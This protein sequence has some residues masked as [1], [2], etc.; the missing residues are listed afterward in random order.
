MY[1][2]E[3]APKFLHRT[4]LAFP[5]LLY[6][7]V[8][9]TTLIVRTDVG[10]TTLRFDIQLLFNTRDNILNSKR[11]PPHSATAVIGEPR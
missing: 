5:L 11:I 10:L 1:Y 7:G 3:S 4:C 9:R 2:T 6:K 8:K